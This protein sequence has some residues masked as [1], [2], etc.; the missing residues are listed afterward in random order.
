MPL[1]GIQSASLSLSQSQAQW[2]AII[3]IKATSPFGADLDARTSSAAET[4][5]AMLPGGYGTSA[6]LTP[7]AGAGGE[8]ETL[9]AITERVRA[10]Q[11]ST[12]D[13]FA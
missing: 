5:D 7:G 1:P 13:L 10:A 3:S 9:A 12:I 6:N 8:Q 2:D 11:Q 4:L